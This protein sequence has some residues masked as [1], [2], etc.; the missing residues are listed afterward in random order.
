[1]K[2]NL[3]S[4]I[5]AV[6]L[7]LTCI[8]V[9]A[10]NTSGQY[11]WDLTALTASNYNADSYTSINSVL[12]VKANPDYI[13]SDGIK[14][15]KNNNVRIK[16]EPAVDS[17]VTVT[18]S[19]SVILTDYEKRK[20]GEENIT[21]DTVIDLTAGTVYYLHGS[22]SSSAAVTAIKYTTKNG[23]PIATTP[24]QETT[25]PE[26][27]S[28]APTTEPTVTPS[29]APTPTATPIPTAPPDMEFDST[30]D[31]TTLTDDDYNADDYTA[32]NDVISIKSSPEYV[33][34]DGVKLT[35]GN[36]VRIKVVPKADGQIVISTSR[37]VLM[38]NYEDRKGSEAS[39]NDNELIDV[40]A[41][42]EYYI[43][44]SSSSAATVKTIK[45]KEKTFELFAVTGV[46]F[47]KD[48]T[49]VL[50]FDIEKGDDYEHDVTACI[51]IYGA[52]GVLKKIGIRKIQSKT[53]IIGSNTVK[54]D[55]AING[56]DK[57]SDTLKI[58]LLSGLE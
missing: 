40:Y 49:K 19:G 18:L 31:L 54:C 11:T 15:N 22:T 57:E 47:N 52:D 53:L 12:S 4:L 24:P 2:K 46:G 27:T 10:D 32:V 38:P 16:L 35:K 29:P 17:T 13:T 39:I 8:P 41:G 21:S 23:D 5:T 42:V 48:Y 25:P 20:G 33:T 45:F 50:E 30:W 14:V 37:S 7:A 44:G 34:S 3:I 1:M 28:P 55:I 26:E 6:I 43:Q 9:L 56:Y 58:L 51:C 36:N